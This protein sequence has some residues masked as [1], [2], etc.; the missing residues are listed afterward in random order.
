MDTQGSELVIQWY[1]NLE[2]R[3]SQFLQYVPY[4]ENNKNAVLPLLSSIILETGSLIDTI[5]REEFKETKKEEKKLTIGDFSPYYETSYNFSKKKTLFYNFP[6][7]YIEPFANWYDKKKN[8]YTPIDWWSN[9]NQIKHNRIK[10]NNL[11]TLEVTVKALCALHQTIS[12]LPTFLDAIFR[13]DMVY[14]G[15]GTKSVRE[16]LLNKNPNITVLVE[17][18]LFATTLGQTEFPENIKDITRF[19]STLWSPKFR[20]HTGRD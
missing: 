10:K 6:L 17:T 2:S 1:K 5:F 7:S 20:R 18:E 16:A 19:S 8:E 15:F 9:Y 4:D 14:H 12:Q 11:S 3:F 13:H